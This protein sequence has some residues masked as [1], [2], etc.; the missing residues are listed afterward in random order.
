MRGRSDA[1]LFFSVVVSYVASE[2]SLLHPPMDTSFLE[3]LQSGG[4]CVAKP[5]LNTTLGENPSASPRLH[6]QEFDAVTS[7]AVA[8]S[9]NLAAWMQSHELR[10]AEQL[11]VGF[12]LW[13]ALLDG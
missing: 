4:L 2:G 11:T 8:H 6:Q 7:H 10:L 12:C 3:C 1:L 9:G 5:G 13:R